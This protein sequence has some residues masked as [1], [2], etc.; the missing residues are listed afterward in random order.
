ML[1]SNNKKK[2]PDMRRL[3]VRS[4]IVAATLAATLGPSTRVRAQSAYPDRPV[5]FVV[6]YPA[7]GP[8][9]SLTRAFADRFKNRIN[10]QSLVVNRPTAIR[11][12]CSRPR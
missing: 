1:I 10:G 2:G 9:D 5:Q 8:I 3:L 12:W 6:P 7:G 11:C 4:L